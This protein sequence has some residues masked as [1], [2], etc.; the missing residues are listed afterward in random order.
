MLPVPTVVLLLKM[1]YRL[2]MGV[3]LVN[4]DAPLPGSVKSMVKVTEFRPDT[5]VLTVDERPS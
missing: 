3:L 1:K 4:E 2:S 5:T